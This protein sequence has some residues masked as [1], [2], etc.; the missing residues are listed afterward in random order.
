MDVHILGPE[1]SYYYLE[2]ES[3][4]IATTKPEPRTWQDNMGL[5]R[6]HRRN[7]SQ[8]LVALTSR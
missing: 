4:M 3:K 8:E 7:L 1:W 6:A 2:K 5:R